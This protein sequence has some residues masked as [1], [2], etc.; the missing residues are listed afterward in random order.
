MAE[1]VA[2]I[3]REIALPVPYDA[4]RLFAFLAGRAIP[5]VETVE[6]LA[7]GWRYRRSLRGATGPALG[8]IT[9]ADGAARIT[10]RSPADH[11]A[12]D[13]A[14]GALDAL[15]RVLD[16]GPSPALVDGALLQQPE[17]RDL[18]TQ[19]PGLRVPRAA[20]RSEV[21]FRALVGQQVSVAAASTTCGF[22]AERFGDELPATLRAGR[23]DRLW[24][25][26]AVLAALNPAALPMP[27]AKA[28]AVTTLAAALRDG[29]VDLTLPGAEVRPQLIA[30][31][32]IGPWTAGY[33]AMRAC[34]D[35]DVLLDAD[36][37]A[38]RGAEL[39]GLPSAPRAL[40]HA[41]RRFAP[42][43]SYLTMHLWSA[44]AAR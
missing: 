3:T 27:R 22:I 26:P 35:S 19:R 30:L 37:I 40:R 25:S 39:V 44:Y 11:N 18:V 36:L 41:G 6:R 29:D 9:V 7:G 24:P 17:T 28:T 21:A 38:R 1:G 15:E 5:G 12:D 4:D 23:I 8:E 31:R 42:W 2:H 34:G 14:L 43:R 10:V 13:V 20:D 32:G 33:I 16:L